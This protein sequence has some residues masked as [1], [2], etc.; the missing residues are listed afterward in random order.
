MWPSF[1]VLCRIRMST[2]YT[3]ILRCSLQKNCCVSIVSV[4]LGLIFKYEALEAR[5]PVDYFQGWLLSYCSWDA[6]HEHANSSLYWLVLMF[7]DIFALRIIHH[8][9][10]RE[11]LKGKKKRS[12]RKVK[13]THTYHYFL[14]YNCLQTVPLLCVAVTSCAPTQMGWIKVQPKKL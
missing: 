6:N 14:C 2:V 5:W 8:L 7:P 12:H 9:F 10:N 13:Q 3:T 11:L 1:T 4:Q